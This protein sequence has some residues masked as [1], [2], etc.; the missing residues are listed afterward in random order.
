MEHLNIKQAQETAGV[1]RDTL[2]RYIKNGRLKAV[3]SC[4][5]W[6]IAYDDLAKAFPHI[7]FTTGTKAGDRR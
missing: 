1:C 5:R 4:G 2:E 7:L 6:Y 3:K